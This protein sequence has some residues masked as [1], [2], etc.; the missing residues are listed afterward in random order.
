[1]S[2]DSTV[3]GT[4]GSLVYIRGDSKMIP[5][6][7]QIFIHWH[8]T[9][10]HPRNLKARRHGSST[11]STDS[12]LLSLLIS[13]RTLIH[14]LGSTAKLCPSLT[15]NPIKTSSFH[16]SIVFCFYAWKFIYWYFFSF[17]VFSALLFFISFT[18]SPSF[19]TLS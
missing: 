17:T 19:V 3:A 5:P 1:M 18:V 6:S 2:C 12:S 9:A 4:G 13:S 11:F 15:N 10:E 14:L 8:Y 7:P 16:F